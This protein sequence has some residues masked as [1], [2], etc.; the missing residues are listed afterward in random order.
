MM[1]LLQID[2]NTH[3]VDWTCIDMDTTIDSRIFDTCRLKS[4]YQ[5]H[6]IHTYF[7]WYDRLVLAKM[8]PWSYVIPP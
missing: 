6:N 4:I 5:S 7:F 3:D 2:L 1:R 8:M